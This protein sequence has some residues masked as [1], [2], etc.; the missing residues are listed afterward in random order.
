MKR[1]ILLAILA[2]LAVIATPAVASAGCL[3][4]AGFPTYNSAG[5]IESNSSISCSTNNGS[6][7]TVRSYI[8]GN[9]GGWHSVNL[10]APYVRTFSSPSDGFSTS[11]RWFMQC[12]YFAAADT[13][14]RQKVTVTN[15]ATGTKD[16]AYS[17]ANSNMPTSC[18]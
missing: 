1:F 12:T 8:Q 14:F 11:W 3:A 17:G 18:Q 16:E 4:G 13:M 2:A 15:D 5:G 7:Y 10:N 6:H 9:S